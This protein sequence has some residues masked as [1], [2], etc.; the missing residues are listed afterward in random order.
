MKIHY[1]NWRPNR[2]INSKDEFLDFN[3]LTMIVSS[4]KMQ[5]YGHYTKLYGDIYT[6]HKLEQL[7][8]TDVWNF[9]DGTSLDKTID[10]NVYDTLSF[11]N[12]G[13]FAILNMEKAPCMLMDTDLILW[14]NPHDLFRQKALFTHWEAIYPY[15]KWYCSKDDL[16]LSA[17]YQ[18]KPCWDFRLPATNTSILYFQNDSLKNYYC[19]EAL[20]FLKNNFISD[21]SIHP[22]L[23]FVEQRLFLMC[24]QEKGALKF[25]KPVID[26]VWNPAKGYFTNK[27]A[28][29][30]WWSFYSPDPSEHITH[31]WIAKKAMEGNQKYKN[32]YCCRLIEEIQKLSPSTLSELEN[33]QMFERYFRLLNRFGNTS[34]I[35]QN[36][37][38][39]DIL[40]SP[41]NKN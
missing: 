17:G 20:R 28:D 29:L 33:L 26:T 30:N 23:L 37:K 9:L 8:L 6:I 24:L 34:S 11:F 41:F 12:I 31:T 39:T 25:T 16:R 1:L 3:L 27:Q 40:Y 2:V 38:A 32:Y 15:S 4:L 22:E 7:H 19:R 36:G 21:E 14:K 10:K 5:S 35:L 18:L 13:K